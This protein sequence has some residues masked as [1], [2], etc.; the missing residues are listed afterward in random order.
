LPI[1]QESL[2]FVSPRVRLTD[3]NPWGNRIRT[4]CSCP[5]IP[6]CCPL[7]LA[8]LQL[9]CHRLDVLLLTSDLFI[10]LVEFI[11]ELGELGKHEVHRDETILLRSIQLFE[12]SLRCVS[13]RC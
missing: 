8:T 4:S 2:R 10:L 9:R 1:C 5:P 3:N 7:V 13:E 11:D 6:S 12:F